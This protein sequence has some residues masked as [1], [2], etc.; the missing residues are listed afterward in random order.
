MRSWRSSCSIISTIPL[1]PACSLFYSLS[2]SLPFPSKSWA[3]WAVSSRRWH[4][5][6]WK[7][8]I[9]QKLLVVSTLDIPKMSALDSHCEQGLVPRRYQLQVFHLLIRQNGWFK[10][11]WSW[12][13]TAEVDPVGS[14]MEQMCWVVVLVGHI[15]L[16]THLLPS[17]VTIQVISSRV[18]AAQKTAV[19]FPFPPRIPG[20]HTA[21]GCLLLAS[22]SH[23]PGKTKCKPQTQTLC[24][25]TSLHSKRA[26]GGKQKELFNLTSWN[27]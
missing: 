6:R 27:R 18:L 20:A 15:H 3:S 23:T 9:K 7:A 14:L 26:N 1:I 24:R 22:W 25:R 16:Q 21:N 17:V 2:P 13:S 19:L 10:T 11:E 12:G 4:M 5:P 8:C